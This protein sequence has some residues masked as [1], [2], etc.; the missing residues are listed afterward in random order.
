MKKDILTEILFLKKKDK[1]RYKKDFIANLL[2]LIQVRRAM[3]Q[4]MKLVEYKYLLVNLKKKKKRKRQQNK[5]TR[6]GNKK[7]KTSYNKPKCISCQ[8]NT[9]RL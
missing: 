9:D 8:K 7:I 3:M 6:R 1:K 4:T 5:R 2:E